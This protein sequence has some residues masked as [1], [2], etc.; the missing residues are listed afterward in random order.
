MAA[1]HETVDR[2]IR[3]EGA[4]HR[5]AVGIAVSSAE[6]GDIVLEGEVAD[7]ASKKIA[8]ERAA[9]VPGVEHV[10]DRLRVGVPFGVPDGEILD[11]VRRMFLEARELADLELAVVTHRGRT[12]VH[13]GGPSPLGRIDVSVKE[14]VVTLDGEVESLAHKRFAGT[15][16]WWVAGVRDVVNG[17]GVDP[18]QQDDD[19]EL[20]DAVR[21]ALEADP[22][23]ESARIGVAASGGVVT[24]TGIAR[25]PE[26]KDAAEFDAWSTFGVDRVE[27]AIQV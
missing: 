5:G 3:R 7:L 9:A 16:A 26:E 1:L 4:I 18:P 10:I 2:A 6:N 21:L 14:G 22:T 19:G 8:L 12:A 25:S 23:V 27:S 20:L 17:L 15:L 11:R 13:D 24:L